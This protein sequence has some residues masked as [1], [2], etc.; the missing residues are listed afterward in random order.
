MLAQYT[1]IS[2]L[3]LINMPNT[4]NAETITRCLCQWFAVLLWT[5]LSLRSTQQIHSFGHNFR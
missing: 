2:P 4:P 3:L 1:Y 5:Q